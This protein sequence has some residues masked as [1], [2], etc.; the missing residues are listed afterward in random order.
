MYV[1]FFFFFFFALLI[2]RPIILHENPARKSHTNV[3]VKE[4]VSSLITREPITNSA[5][6]LIFR[7]LYSASFKVFYPTVKNLKVVSGNTRALFNMA[8][9]FNEFPLYQV[10]R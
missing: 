10:W 3:S 2:L 7:S 1:F 6:G 9:V 8:A 5:N 4:S